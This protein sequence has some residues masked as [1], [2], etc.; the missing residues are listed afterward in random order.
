VKKMSGKRNSEAT[1]TM[2]AVVSRVMTK[3]P[4]RVAIIEEA[5]TVTTKPQKHSNGMPV[6][7]A[8]MRRN[9]FNLDVSIDARG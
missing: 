3:A 2:K 7:S 4:K 1:K 8:L 5:K 6:R 9:A